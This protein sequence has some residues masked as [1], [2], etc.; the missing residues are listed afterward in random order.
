MEENL[1]TPP[2]LLHQSLAFESFYSAWRLLDDKIDFKTISD[3]TL[4]WIVNGAFACEIGMKYILSRNGISISKVHLLHVL[5]NHLPNNDKAAIWDRLKSSY[6]YQDD[7]INDS[8]L[9]ISNAFNNFRYSYERTLSIDMDFAANFFNAVYEQV[10]LYPRVAVV[11]GGDV[12]DPIVQGTV[13][14]QMEQTAYALMKESE[15]YGEG[16]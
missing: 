8:I 13:D 3:Y 7:Y 2:P 12:T 9:L 6:S 16:K 11:Y 4:P 10:R 1:P 15:K 5:F 14:R